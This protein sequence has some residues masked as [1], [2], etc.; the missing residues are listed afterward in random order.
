MSL[1]IYITNYCKIFLKKLSNNKIK[2]LAINQILEKNFPEGDN[3][4]VIIVGAND[5]TSHDSIHLF[6]KKRNCQG[7][8]IEPIKSSFNKL[9]LNFSF[10]DGI[11]KIN[12]AVHPS[13]KEVTMYVPNP[14]KLTELPEWASG[15]ASLSREHHLKSGIDSSYVIEEQVPSDTLMNILSEYYPNQKID[16][17]QIDTEGFDYEV[18]KQIDFKKINPPLIRYEY[19]NLSNEDIDASRNLLQSNGYYCIHDEIDMLGIK[20]SKIRL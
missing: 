18:L 5:G 7:L 9:L 12:K 20:L 1:P 2:K 11:K 16:L 15:I 6:L 8:A 17:L 3:F 19:T 4:S 13:L 10:A 14:Q